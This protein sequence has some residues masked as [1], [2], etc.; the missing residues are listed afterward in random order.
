MNPASLQRTCC[1]LEVTTTCQG[2][3]KNG[4]TCD[5]CSAYASPC[6]G[7]R[8]GCGQSSGIDHCHTLTRSQ[9]C[10]P[11]CQGRDLTVYTDPS[12]A[13]KDLGMASPVGLRR[14]AAL[15]VVQEF[16]VPQPAAGSLGAALM[17]Q[18]TQQL[19]A[20]AR[21]HQ[22]SILCLVC[23]S[24]SLQSSSR[25]AHLLCRVRKEPH[26]TA[27]LTTNHCASTAASQDP[28]RCSRSSMSLQQPC[29][30]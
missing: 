14:R 21:L 11:W 19:H 10:K 8:S 16:E 5:G 28:S 2:H 23:W 22:A 12:G 18:C 6:R 24:H 30:Q 25:Q 20:G 26:W 27:Q 3:C 9:S 15:P 17:P 13:I 1:F 29:M 7:I 4:F